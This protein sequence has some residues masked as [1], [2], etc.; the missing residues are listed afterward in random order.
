MTIQ[1]YA[2]LIYMIL[3]CATMF[4]LWSNY[5]GYKYSYKQA[6]RW[7]IT[8]RNEVN[9]LKKQLEKFNQKD[10]PDEKHYGC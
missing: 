1:Q 8:S 7:F 9:E 2:F 4:W 10:K 5:V 6:M 3:S